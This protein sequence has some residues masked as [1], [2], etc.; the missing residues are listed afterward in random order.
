VVPV[1]LNSMG[2]VG[3]TNHVDVRMFF[4]KELHE[5]GMVVFKHI[6]GPDNEADIFTKNANDGLLHRHSVKLC[7]DVG[8]LGMMKS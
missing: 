2:I 4:L 3:R 5:D 7:S 8:L 6:L 1:T